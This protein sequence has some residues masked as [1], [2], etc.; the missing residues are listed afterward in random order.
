VH[1]SSGQGIIHHQQK[2]AALIIIL[3]LTPS[4]IPPVEIPESREMLATEDEEKLLSLRDDFLRCMEDIMSGSTLVTVT[5]E[6]PAKILGNAVPALAP[7]RMSKPVTSD[8][9]SAEYL[10]ARKASGFG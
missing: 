7:R 1:Y 10:M 5:E 4:V 9:E 3:L 2:E 6:G 8:V